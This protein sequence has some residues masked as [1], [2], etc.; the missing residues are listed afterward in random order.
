MVRGGGMKGGEEER[1][2]ER[3]EREKGEREEREREEYD[4]DF[5]SFCTPVLLCD[6][7]DPKARYQS[8]SNKCQDQISRNKY[9]GILQQE[10][11]QR[12]FG[13]PGSIKK[14]GRK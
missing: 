9:K 13:V 7:I 8:Q 3:G 5:K 6:L 14:L 12:G 4:K 2:R 10:I 11:C 1:E